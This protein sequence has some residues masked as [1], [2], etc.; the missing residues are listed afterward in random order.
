MKKVDV[1]EKPR[2]DPYPGTSMADY[3][4]AHGGRVGNA[5]I[6]EMKSLRE[7]MRDHSRRAL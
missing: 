6:A 3:L 4:K 5:K 7:K 2:P 1:P